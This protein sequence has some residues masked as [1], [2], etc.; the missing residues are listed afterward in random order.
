MKD[1]AG[2]A[3]CNTHSIGTAELNIVD[4]CLLCRLEKNVENH[5]CCKEAFGME[6]N[7]KIG[8]DCRHRLDKCLISCI[9]KNWLSRVSAL[10]GVELNS[11][12]SGQGGAILLSLLQSCLKIFPAACSIQSQYFPTFEL[13][14]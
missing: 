6:K 5:I 11:Y 14:F 2:F 12:W 10:K 4:L 8:S 9:N 13:S 3:F 7:E 1:L